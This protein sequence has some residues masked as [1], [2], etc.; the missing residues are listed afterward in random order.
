MTPA[1]APLPRFIPTLT[2]VVDP[3][4]LAETVSPE[5]A[6]VSHLIADLEHQLRPILE[7]RLQQEVTR[8]MQEF[9]A[10]YWPEVSA[11]L[12]Q[13]MDNLVRQAASDALAPTIQPWQAE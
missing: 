7:Q 6:V 11:R 3:A 2:E 8:L 1:P 9:L 4:S 10:Q 13:D 5:P 12:R